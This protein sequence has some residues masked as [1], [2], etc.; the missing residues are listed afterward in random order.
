MGFKRLRGVPLPEKRQGLI[1][2]TCLCI[3]TQP[4]WVQRKVER[5]CR[6]VGGDYAEALKEVMCTNDS[7]TSIAIR[8][9]VSE[10]TLY[11]LRKKFYVS[12]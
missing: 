10:T 5:L 9:Y 8:H 4:Q 1:R 12:W 3:E 6:E 11:R 7:I 2:Y